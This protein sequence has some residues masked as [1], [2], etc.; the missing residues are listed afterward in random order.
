MLAKITVAG[1]EV[2]KCK[3]KFGVYHASSGLAV[4]RPSLSND[5]AKL[6]LASLDGVADW[7][8]EKDALLAAFKLD[9]LAAKCQGL[10][11][12]AKI[13]GAAVT[14]ERK[15]A[16]LAAPLK[17]PKGYKLGTIKLTTRDGLVKIEACIR[18]GLAFHRKHSVGT[19]SKYWTVTHVKTGLGTTHGKSCNSARA[20]KAL[21]D[22]LLSLGTWTV[23][24]NQIKKRGP[25]YI[26]AILAEISKHAD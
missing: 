19:P 14:K 15:A 20:A 6:L 26:Q 22:G 16:R 7:T 10:A 9:D 8:L 5:G 23:T 4:T 18:D 25:A 24:A 3:S 11:D 12:A 1:L 21:C 2:R 17:A 13:K